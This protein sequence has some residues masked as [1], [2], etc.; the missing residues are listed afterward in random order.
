M[1][2]AVTEG[3]G[4]VKIVEV[5]IPE[6]G[7]YQCLCKTLACATC[8]GTD[9][10]IIHGKLPW[11]EEYPAIFGHES[12]GT[13]LKTGDKVRYIK[14]GETYLRPTAVY[15]G[16]KFGDFY[17]IWGGFSEYGLIT[18]LKALLEDNPGTE[19][20]YMQYQMNIPS[21]VKISPAEAIM[22]ITLKETAGFVADMKISLNKSV[23]VLGAGPV[24][25]SMCLFAKFFGAFPLI[26]VAR[27]DE[28]LENIRRFGVNFTV[29]NSKENLVEKIREITGGKGV[30]FIIDT[31]GDEKLF[32]E[33]YNMLAGNGKIAPYATF[34]KDDALKN[35]DE[36][37]ILRANTG[38]VPAHNYL[39]DL[40]QM[41]KVNLK[42]F[43]SHTMPFSD[44]EKGFEMLKKREAFKIVFEM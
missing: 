20:G 36:M 22:L 32:G 35:L 29:N 8:S 23:A 25:M 21:D 7:P 38:E 41:N 12:V 11:K 43:Y 16:Q 30:D 10:K 24:A 15:P 42:D 2:A 6:P 14:K 33:A 40:V 31:A 44:I 28:P 17:S 27:R 39:L 26:A 19:P 3:K 13:V 1:K 37:K 18:D 9:M 4:D 5:P 34:T